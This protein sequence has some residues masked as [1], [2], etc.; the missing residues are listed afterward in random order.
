MPSFGGYIIPTSSIVLS[1]NCE[2][3]KP[4]TSHKKGISVFHHI[5]VTWN[6]VWYRWLIMDKCKLTL[7][8]LFDPRYSMYINVWSIYLHLGSLGVHV[9]KY[10]IH[11]V[12]PYKPTAFCTLITG[13]CLLSWDRI[14]FQFQATMFSSNGSCHTRN[15]ID[16]NMF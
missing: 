15:C 7:Y 3:L 8:S 9:G 16:E 2:G 4:I 14:S 5:C 1:K 11:S 12:P 10:T 13:I 6:Q